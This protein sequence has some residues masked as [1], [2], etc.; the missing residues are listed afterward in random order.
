MRYALNLSDDGRVLSA[1]YAEY[2]SEENPVV[3]TLPE[4]DIYDYRY[5]DGEFLYYPTGIVQKE[6]IM[7]RI[8]ELKLALA[9]TDYNILKIVEGA[10][11]IDEM[12]DIISKRS[13]WRKEI[14]ELEAELG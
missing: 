9:D 6:T 2:A 1:T 10:A 12:A 13:K 3:S 7:Q 14:N 4:G 11:T 8:A 5:V